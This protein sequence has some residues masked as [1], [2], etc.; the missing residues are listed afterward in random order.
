MHAGQES[1]G[2][3]IE[4]E[5]DIAM[6]TMQCVIALG[7]MAGILC[8]STGAGAAEPAA[9]PQQKQPAGLNAMRV[10]RDAATGELRAPTTEELQA[11]LAAEQ[12]ARQSTAFA[13]SATPT[14]QQVLP[15]EKSIVRHANGMV[16]M[17][18]SQESL[19]AL[20]AMT[21]A[22]GKVHVVHDAPVLK[23]QPQLEEK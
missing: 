11:L 9:K 4:N 19:S 18:L 8:V 12:A 20:K 21:D 16:S 22:Q 23:A 2:V 14:A 13:R 1:A 10:V 7:A 6:R 15:A 17:Q 3:T 5:G